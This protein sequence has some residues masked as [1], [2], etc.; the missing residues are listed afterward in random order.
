MRVGL[1]GGTGHLGSLLLQRLLGWPEVESVVSVA[2]RPL[3]AGPLGDP[4]SG[5][6]PDAVSAAGGADR[7]RVTHVRADLRA[8]EARRALE[9]VDICFHL[10][11]QLWSA[12]A[13]AEMAEA[14]LRG[15]DNV[16][17]A[18][19]GAV[20]LASSAAVYGAWPANPV[21]L[22]EQ[23][24]PRPN[25]EVPYAQHKLGA[26]T[27]CLDA[28]PTVVVRLAAVLGPHADAAVA[29][30]VAGYRMAVPAVRGVAQAVQFLDEQDAVEA[31]L[32]AG[33][34]VLGGG[35]PGLGGGGPGLGGGGVGL[36]GGSG[37]VLNAATTD[38]LS[39]SDIAAV[40]GGRVLTVSRRLLLA[41]SEAGR[42]AR[43]LPFG[44]DRAAL[45]G[46]PLALDSARAGELLGWAPTR[47]SAA[48][49]AEALGASRR[50]AARPDGPRPRF[51]R[52][53]E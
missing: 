37:L 16:L 30:S 12:G 13:P 41:A 25:P 35:G 29:R 21:P 7:R 26:E 39:A 34:A 32:A 3:G 31:L 4:L 24:P 22:R 15:T 50:G 48:V 33:R 11:F 19:P 14:N 51:A 20:V 23:D 49:L 8:P 9:R 2:R 43:L 44:A 47:T 36:A 6:G 10:G 45:L 27:R 28:A 40:S 5:G 42:R 1:T 52:R 46:G 17:A 18:R 53:A 38:W